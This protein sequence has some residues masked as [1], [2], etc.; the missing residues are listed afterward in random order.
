[1]STNEERHRHE[2]P[3]LVKAAMQIAVCSPVDKSLKKVAE[4]FLVRQFE[5]DTKPLE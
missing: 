1:M 4:A 2:L 5:A 3:E